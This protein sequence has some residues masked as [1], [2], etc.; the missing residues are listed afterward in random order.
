MEIVFPCC[1]GL[2]V[3]KASVVACLV[4]TG[5]DGGRRA[6]ET[7]TFAT[8]TDALVALG[9]WLRAAGCQQV[10][11]ESTGVYWQPVFNILTEPED[12]LSVWEVN[13]QTTC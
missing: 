11:M 13:A 10:A 7:R 6:K 12:E 2:D 3:H 8:T 4:T 1:A 5:A 9:E